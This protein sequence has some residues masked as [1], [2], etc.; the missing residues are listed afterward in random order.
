MFANVSNL[1]WINKKH[2][3]VKK[4]L[5]FWHKLTRSYGVEQLQSKIDD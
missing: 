4:V 1:K 2:S 3:E 5:S